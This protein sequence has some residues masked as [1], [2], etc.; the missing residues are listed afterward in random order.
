MKALNYIP[1]IVRNTIIP[2]ADWH[3]MLGSGVARGTALQ[4][5]ISAYQ[6]VY[7]YIKKGFP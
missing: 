2:G 4:L 5:L 7:L 1:N 3:V 6:R